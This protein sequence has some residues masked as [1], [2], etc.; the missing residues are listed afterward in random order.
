MAFDFRSAAQNATTISKLMENRTRLTIDDV[1]K[2]YPQGVTITGFDLVQ[3]D[4]NP[5]AV[6]ICAEAPDKFFFGGSILTKIVNEWV[7][8]Y[9]GDIDAASSDLGESGG[10]RMQFSHGRTKKGNSLTLVKVL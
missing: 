3:S 1:I 8:S 7:K 5:Y 6:V 10:V 2:N 4:D 9:D